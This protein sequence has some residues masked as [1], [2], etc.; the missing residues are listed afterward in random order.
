MRMHLIIQGTLPVTDHSVTATCRSS[1]GRS[2][3]TVCPPAQ[4]ERSQS[5][6]DR[7]RQGEGAGFIHPKNYL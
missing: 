6:G 2:A 3:V 4:T 1:E 7:D 5:G